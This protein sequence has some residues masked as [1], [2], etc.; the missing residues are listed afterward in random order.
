[1]GDLG[2]F[3]PYANRAPANDPFKVSCKFNTSR[4]EKE[5]KISRYDE[6]QI[7]ISVPESC[8]ISYQDKPVLETEM[9]INMVARLV[10]VSIFSLA[11][12]QASEWRYNQQESMD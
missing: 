9:D 3:V 7:Y 4:A 8:T 6:H 11:S 2:N 10:L 5:L 1:M 12:L